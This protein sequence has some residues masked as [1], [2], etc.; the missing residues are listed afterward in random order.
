ML[1]T[2]ASVAVKHSPARS[3]S[4]ARSAHPKAS[5]V[6]TYSRLVLY[7]FSLKKA[8]QVYVIQVDV[9]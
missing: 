7:L 4:H 8:I 1:R 9:D 2:S 5:Q 3:N 6:D